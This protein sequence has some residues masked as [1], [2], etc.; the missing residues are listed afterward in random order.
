MAKMETVCITRV[1]RIG[2]LIFF[3][4][5]VHGLHMV[6]GRFGVPQERL[7]GYEKFEGLDPA[8]W[9]AKGYAVANFDLRGVWDSEGI[10]PCVFHVSLSQSFHI[11]NDN[12]PVA[13]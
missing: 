7:S 11:T 13:G 3:Y 2:L 9:V 1:L 10:I 5:G 12:L 4:I 8:E 6:P